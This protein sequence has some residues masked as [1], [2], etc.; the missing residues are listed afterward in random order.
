MRLTWFSGCQRSVTRA[1]SVPIEKSA[2][3]FVYPK[4]RTKMRISSSW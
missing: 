3:R 4:L 2:L 1:L